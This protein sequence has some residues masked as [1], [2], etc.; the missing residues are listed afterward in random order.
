MKHIRLYLQ[1]AAAAMALL[2]VA[3]CSSNESQDI[4]SPEQANPSTYQARLVVKGYSDSTKVLSEMTAIENT[5][6]TY[7]NT[8]SLKTITFDEGSSESNDAA[9]VKQCQLA[10]AVIN[11][12]EYAASY[13]F[14][15]IK[16]ATGD[17]LYSFRPTATNYRME[18]IS[19]DFDEDVLPSGNTG[20]IPQTKY[21][22]DLAVAAAGS[23]SQAQ[24]ELASRG[25]SIITQDLNQGVGGDYV[26][27]GYKQTTSNSQAITNLYIIVEW[28]IGDF[29]YGGASYTAVPYFGNNQGSLNSNTGGK[30]MWLYYTKAQ[31]SNG[32]K[33]LEV[34]S[35]DSRQQNNNFVYG[36]NANLGDWDGYR[37]VDINTNAGS[38]FRYILKNY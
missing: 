4:G 5:L 30:N 34:K 3:G 11:K 15:L 2:A 20:Y 29:T 22:S 28:H 33:T 32:L 10:E 37:G 25:Y 12:N 6:L 13:A 8:K 26:Y 31:N 1:T 9:A 7:L 38:S 19:S 17:T 18:D 14:F 36:L 27:I 16:S 23:E 24:G 35:Y 21:I